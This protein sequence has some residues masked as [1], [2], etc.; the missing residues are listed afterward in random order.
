MVLKTGKLVGV[1]KKKETTKDKILK[2][3]ILGEGYQ[4]EKTA[5]K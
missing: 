4:N 1:Q 5:L 2:M 3:I